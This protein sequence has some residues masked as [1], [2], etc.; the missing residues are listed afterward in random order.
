MLAAVVTQVMKCFNSHRLFKLFITKILT[1]LL[2]NLTS[3]C[4]NDECE[5]FVDIGN[6]PHH[7][8]GNQENHAAENLNQVRKITSCCC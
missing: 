1:P 5:S 7:Q 6:R 4:N 2:C 8:L 3:D